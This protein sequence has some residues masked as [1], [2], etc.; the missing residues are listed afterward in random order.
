MRGDEADDGV[1]HLPVRAVS[2]PVRRG[3]AVT[4]VGV[5]GQSQVG[6]QDINAGLPVLG[7]VV[8]QPGHGVHPS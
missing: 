1:A 6:A 7:P 3:G 4:R 2:G 8:G 5:I